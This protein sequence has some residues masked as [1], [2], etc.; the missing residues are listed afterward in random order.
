[1]SSMWLDLFG[2]ASRK[3]ATPSTCRAASLLLNVLL[4][5]KV[6][7]YLSVAAIVETMLSSVDLHGPAAFCDSSASLWITFMKAKATENP[8]A[9]S[10]LSERILRWVFGKWIPSKH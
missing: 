7:S 8:S 4:K 6:V 1:M 5:L 10:G 3:V 9:S 2:L